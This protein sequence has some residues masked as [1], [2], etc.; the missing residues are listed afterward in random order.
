MSASP[1]KFV[2]PIARQSIDDY[3][4]KWNLGAAAELT[5][6]LRINKV[7]AWNIRFNRTAVNIVQLRRTAVVSL[8]QLILMI[9]S[10]KVGL[11][12][13]QI[14]FNGVYEPSEYPFIIFQFSLYQFLGQGIPHNSFPEFCHGAQLQRFVIFDKLVPNGS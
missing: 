6:R 4:E 9:H 7:V 13:P 3:G 2:V 12:E 14:Y 1:Q 11:W 5:G 10:S 8:L